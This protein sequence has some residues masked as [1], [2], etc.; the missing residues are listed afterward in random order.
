MTIEE[1]LQYNIHLIRRRQEKTLLRTELGHR[2][3]PPSPVPT[4]SHAPVAVR[5]S[6]RRY[7]VDVDDV[8]P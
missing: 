2:Q 8:A 1:A 3:A 5:T 7:D 6:R 4:I